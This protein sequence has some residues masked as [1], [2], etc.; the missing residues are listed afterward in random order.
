MLNVA[1]FV[2]CTPVLVGLAGFDRDRLLTKG[3]DQYISQ[4]LGHGPS[5]L[6]GVGES[7][8]KVFPERGG[9]FK[10]YFFVRT[11]TRHRRTTFFHRLPQPIHVT[12]NLDREF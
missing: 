11:L 2:D 8:R 6:L 10:S 3:A 1:S 4:G 9:S 7:D 12:N 5:L